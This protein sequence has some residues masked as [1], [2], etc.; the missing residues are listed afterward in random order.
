MRCS[1]TNMDV[2]HSVLDVL[3]LSSSPDATLCRSAICSSLLGSIGIFF[4]RLVT[5]VL[6]LSLTLLVSSTLSLYAI[7]LA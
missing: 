7:I 3:S 2:Y 6:D 5:R 1:F 4:V